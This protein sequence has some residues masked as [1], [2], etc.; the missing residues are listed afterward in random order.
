[1]NVAYI[2]LGSN[3]EPK[4]RYL[5]DAIQLLN[6]HEKIS[7]RKQ[8]SIYETEPVDY[9]E[10]DRFL[11]MV[12]EIETSLTSIELLKYCQQIELELGRDRSEMQIEK[13][14][15]TIDL[16][17]LLYNEETS[18]LEKLQLPHPRLHERAFVLVPLNEIAPTLKVPK[19]GKK[20]QQLLQQLPDEAI[21]EVVKWKEK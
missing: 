3:I 14:P 19:L 18:N 10:Q 6:K 12:V 8:S 20:I 13:G 7:L 11:N 21:K 5:A 9:L 2:G 15:R 4:E 17:I 16:D 1:M